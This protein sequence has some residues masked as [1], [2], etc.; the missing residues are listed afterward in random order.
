MESLNRFR[1]GLFIFGT[2]NI[3]S[4]EKVFLPPANA[5]RVICL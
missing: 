5:N 1:L 2:I 4:H 3:L